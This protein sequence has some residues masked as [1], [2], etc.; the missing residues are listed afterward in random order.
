MA[1]AT[2]PERVKYISILICHL[3]GREEASVVN[4]VTRGHGCEVVKLSYPFSEHV[5]MITPWVAGKYG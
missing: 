4:V 1:R 2:P 5:T 3:L